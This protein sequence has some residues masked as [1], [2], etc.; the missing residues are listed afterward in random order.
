[1]KTPRANGKSATPG[2]SDFAGRL[3][4]SWHSLKLPTSQPQVILAVSGGADSTALLLALD[5]LVK[6]KKLSLTLTVA[7]LDH[8]LRKVSREDAVW[9]ENLA[10]ELGHE[11]VKRRTDV[12]KRAARSGD[13]LEQAAR[14]V[15]YEFL[16]NTAKQKQS[17]L[18]ITAHTLDDQAETI[19]LRLLRGSAAEGLSG[20][21]PVRLIDSKSSIQL[22]R[23]LLSWARRSDA[24]NYCR[25]RKVEF[26]IDEMNQDEKY[27]RVKVRKQLLP[28]MLSFN[29]KI[30]EAL[31]RTATLLREDAGALSD[32]ANK[33]LRLASPQTLGKKWDKPARLNVA[34]LASATAAVRRRAL[35]QW[36]SQRRGDLRRLEMVHLMAVDSLIEGNRG[37][38]IAELPDGGKVVRKRGWLELDGSVNGKKG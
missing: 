5:E 9:V 3:F 17:L 38:R 12:K 36:I 23:P 1:M 8:S 27:A 33:L 7:H 30:V 20:I 25:L 22:A 28:L 26:R 32:E 29:N 4:H 13:N 14:R 21:E 37:G 18:V 10:S 31:S 35:R 24:E 34:V 6:A 16:K 15:R 2:I 11:F 19:L